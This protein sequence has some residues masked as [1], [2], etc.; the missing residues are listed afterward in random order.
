MYGNNRIDKKED[1]R[2]ASCYSLHVW[3]GFNPSNCVNPNSII[4]VQHSVETL[5]NRALASLAA[6]LRVGTTVLTALVV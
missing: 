4:A 3:P 6:V 2:K 1:V 5:E